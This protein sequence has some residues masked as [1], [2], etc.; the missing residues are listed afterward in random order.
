MCDVPPG[1]RQVDCTRA[2]LLADEF[3]MKF[4]ETSAK[5]NINVEEMFMSLATDMHN[6]LHGGGVLPAVC[7]LVCSS[8]NQVASSMFPR[9]PFIRHPAYAQLAAEV[10][11]RAAFAS[12][13]ADVFML[14][15]LTNA[16]RVPVLSPGQLLLLI[17]SCGH[18]RHFINSVMPQDV[19]TTNPR[20]ALLRTLFSSS[21]AHRFLAAQSKD[22]TKTVTG[23]AMVTARQLRPSD[24][25][26]QSDSSSSACACCKSL[27]AWLNRRHHCRSCGRLLC[28]ACAPLREIV[29]IHRNVRCCKSCM[30]IMEWKFGRERIVGPVQRPYYNNAY[31]FAPR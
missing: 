9:T 11:S 1:E 13:F 4:F 16:V 3:Q 24:A 2:Q 20:N 25:A 17:C 27:F 21:I 22:K 12:A 19:R 28:D 30:T 18:V 15:G 29:G 7:R 10:A 6:V 31:L 14:D 23:G 26:W 8:R 5:L